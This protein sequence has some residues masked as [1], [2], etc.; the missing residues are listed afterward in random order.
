M[1]HLPVE[2][3]S[4]R[5]RLVRYFPY[6]RSQGIEA[7][8]WPS[9]PSALH[10]IKNTY[11]PGNTL[12][13]ALLLSAALLRRLLVDFPRF[14]HFDALFVHREVFP[15]F[16]PLFERLAQRVNPRFILDF[17]DAVY[18]E[19]THY[20]DWR[21]VLRQP[22]NF[23]QV[24]A[25]SAHVVAGNQVLADY[26]REYNDRVTVVPTALDPDFYPPKRDFDAAPVVVGWTGA[27]ATAP[28]LDLLAPVFER[29]ARTER[30]RLK[31]IGN[32]NIYDLHFPG[33]E[34]EYCLWNLRTM[35]D[36]LRVFDV[37]VMPLPDTP[38]ERG[39]CGGK[40]LQYMALGIPAV[41]SPVGV[42]TQIVADGENGFL[43]STGNEW[44]ECLRALI[45]DAALRKRIGGRARQTMEARYSIKVTG[46]RL[47]AIVEEVAKE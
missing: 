8:F 10:A 23:A 19:P 18:V 17:D 34:V 13:K 24:V 41:A 47:R 26:A 39:K 12:K 44:Y 27:W 22:A 7:T 37:G 6:F 16:T 2:N 9:V 14:G 11:G 21:S 28:S 15:F 45:R 32:A 4:A 38:W 33:V 43:A 30:F 3:Q 20:R 29:L 1:A 5:Q 42:N 25:G 36:D 46:P 31:I 35:I 40:L